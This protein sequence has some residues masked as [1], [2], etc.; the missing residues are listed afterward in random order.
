MYNNPG[1]MYQ[2]DVGESFVM[3]LFERS[4]I[5]PDT[6]LHTMVQWHEMDKQFG[7]D[8]VFGRRP[9]DGNEPDVFL[10]KAAS[11]VMDLYDLL[12]GEIRERFSREVVDP[13]YQ[14]LKDRTPTIDDPKYSIRDLVEELLFTIAPPISLN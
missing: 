11:P 3:R 13:A 9:T 7:D 5:Q 2:A 4:C 8:P 1:K 10:R 6:V 14:S 12:P